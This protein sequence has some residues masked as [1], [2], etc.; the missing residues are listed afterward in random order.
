[1]SEAQTVVPI[2]R[3]SSINL[4]AFD[5][6][7]IRHD[8]AR[9]AL[10]WSMVPNPRPCFSSGMVR[11]I[12]RFQETLRDQFHAAQVRYL[13]VGS[14]MPGVFS[15]G[16][17]LALF[18][19]LIERRDVDGLSAYARDCVTILDNHYR[20]MD[21]PVTS[22]ALVQGDAVG[23]GFET[24]L[25]ADFLIAERGAKL[26]FPEILFNLVPG[27]GAY[28]LL[29]HRIGAR[30]AR[31][32]ILG[33]RLYPAEEIHEMGLI[34]I[35]VEDGEGPAAL[36]KFIRHRN[37]TWNA[38]HALQRIERTTQRITRGQLTE[39]ANIWVE[40]AMRLDTHHLKIMDRLIRAQHRAVNEVQAPVQPAM[41]VGAES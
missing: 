31:D 17:D 27:H 29:S 4:G 28:H 3:S 21:L 30:A 13:V 26:G 5:H 39:S 34:D 1:M 41:A 11:D 12:Q 23:A 10:F 7:E 19:D 25:A 37:K 20:S 36:D 35:L 33:G 18:R 32:M 6:L 38:G 2:Q 8:P 24:A 14:T 22:V 40:A 15:F 16:G 9:Q